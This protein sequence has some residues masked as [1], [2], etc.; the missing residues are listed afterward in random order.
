VLCVEIHQEVMWIA[1][2]RG[3]PTDAR[4]TVLRTD[5]PAAVAAALAGMG[6][7]RFRRVVEVPLCAG[8][9]LDP[10]RYAR[11]REVLEEG[12][13]RYWRNRLTLI[14]L[15][16]LQVRNILGNLPLLASAADFSALATRLP[17]VVAGA[18]PSL[19]RSIPDL[20]S[21]RDR[22]ALAAVDT[23]LPA[24]AAM[25][26]A[27][28]VVIALEAQMANLQDFIPFRTGSAL[29]ACDLSSYPP[30]ARL[31]EGRLALFSSSF[32]P[33][34]IFD[35][36]S[37]SGLLPTPFP[38]LGSVGVA[39]AHAALRLTQGDVFLTGLDFSYPGAL[40]HA[41]GTPVH[42]AAL[43]GARR[44]RPVGEDSFKAISARPLLRIPD[45]KGKPVATDLVLRSYRDSLE[46]EMRESAHR[47]Y[48]IGES[49][50]SLG[51]PSITSSEFRERL[52]AAPGGGQRLE[53]DS[54]SVRSP[55][56]LREF[57]ASEKELLRKAISASAEPGA[58]RT[59][60]DELMALLSEIDYAWVHFP[61]EPGPGAPT[62]GFIARVRVAAGYYAQRLERMGSVI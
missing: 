30:A 10:E 60:T 59:G 48:D 58:A 21:L 56:V 51:V 8:Y 35:R 4:L 49:G 34:R 57:V 54:G 50:L 29:L 31:F 3:L 55:H 25:G 23:A 12:I 44:M 18:G 40:T 36:L 22:F 24:L 52:S 20:T 32:A 16:S 7:R 62:P 45:K 33:L 2:E 17:V 13:V 41:R 47:V 15:G 28:D 14:A 26:I 5:D 6:Q 46:M 61:D 1:I 39:A 53:I 38:A 19:D 11:F 43:A 9:R 27:P 37:R 42:I